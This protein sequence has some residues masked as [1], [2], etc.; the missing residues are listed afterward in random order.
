MAIRI[1][2]F[3][4]LTNLIILFFNNPLQD[5]T[6]TFKRQLEDKRA[7]IENNLLTG[8]QRLQQ[9]DSST[10]N[11]HLNTN[12]NSLSSDTSESDGKQFKDT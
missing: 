3:I 11:F 1:Y 7:I 6:R 10:G 2:S 5:E 12:D 8:R 4:H 9:A